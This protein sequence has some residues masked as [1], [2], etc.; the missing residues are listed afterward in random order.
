MTETD[1]IGQTPNL[2]SLAREGTTELEAQVFALIEGPETA[3]TEIVLVVGDNRASGK[4]A[5]EALL[6]EVGSRNG[7]G[8]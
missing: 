3:L 4:G 6:S 5:D 2:G 8:R 1:E 7:F